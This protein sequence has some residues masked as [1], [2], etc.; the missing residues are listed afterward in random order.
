MKKEQKMSWEEMSNYLTEHN[1]AVGVVVVKQHPNWTQQYTLEERSYVVYG[2]NKYFN[3]AMIGSSIFS[4]TLA[5]T[6]VGVR[7]DWYLF[8]TDKEN[9]WQIDYCYLLEK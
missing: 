9:R 8:D 3:P 4:R 5:N 7:L 1:N 2:D 6:D